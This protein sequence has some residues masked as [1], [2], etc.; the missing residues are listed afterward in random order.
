M[1]KAAKHSHT[2]NDAIN[3]ETVNIS[4]SKNSSECAKRRL[5]EDLVKQRIAL[6]EELQEEERIRH[7]K[8]AAILAELKALVDNS[9]GKGD[10]AEEQ[11]ADKD[12]ALESKGSVEI[13]E[14]EDYRELKE[15]M[16]E[17]HDKYFPI[18]VYTKEQLGEAR[19]SGAERILVKGD[20]AKKLSSAFKGLGALSSTSLNTLALCLSGAALFAP[21]TGGVSLGAAGTV[22]GTVGAALTATAIAAISAIGLSLVLAVFRGY[23]EIKLGGGGVE[24]VI[25][26]HKDKDQD[27]AQAKGNADSNKAEEKGN[28][29]S[30]KADAKKSEAKQAVDSSDEFSKSG[31]DNDETSKSSSDKDDALDKSKSLED[32]TA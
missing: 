3:D 32:K 4:D 31:T 24:L 25:K 17:S 8:E 28:A 6:Y 21:F 30:N 7:Q 11:D 5:K 15:R 23:D 19:K 13:N 14:D 2:K 22:M 1:S 9:E 20:L 12:D 29:D 18:V 16:Q 26:K 27:K 10:K